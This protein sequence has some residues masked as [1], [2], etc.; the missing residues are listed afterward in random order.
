M[1]QKLTALILIGLIAFVI[2]GSEAISC[3]S[4]DS[5]TSSNCVDPF[6]ASGVSTCTG[7]TCTKAWGTGSGVT[8]VIRGCDPTPVDKDL[9]ADVSASGVTVRACV[10]KS[11]NCND[12][13]MLAPMYKT[14]VAVMI[15]AIMAITWV[16]KI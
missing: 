16:N 11:N 1:D 15:A 7:A 2:G 12:G 9:C 8:L 13:G 5:R 14:V 3:Y 6:S 10:C 4:C